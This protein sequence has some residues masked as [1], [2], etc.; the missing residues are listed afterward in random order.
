[1][2]QGIC[3]VDPFCEI[4]NLGGKYIHNHMTVSLLHFSPSPRKKVRT[5]WL[6]YALTQAQSAEVEAAVCSK[7]FEVLSQPET[8]HRQKQ[9][10]SF[11]PAK[12]DVK[13]LQKLSSGESGGNF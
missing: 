6:W 9:K 4:L 8:P 2:A 11:K 10:P 12:N 13:V 7:N 3:P 1:M 5:M